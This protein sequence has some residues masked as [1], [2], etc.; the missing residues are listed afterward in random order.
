MGR[1]VRY[2]TVLDSTGVALGFILQLPIGVRVLD[3]WNSSTPFPPAVLAVTDSLGPS[4]CMYEDSGR[5]AEA[6]A[7]LVS[8]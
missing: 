5:A 3:R 7:H 2:P 8:F 4:F 6:A 1:M